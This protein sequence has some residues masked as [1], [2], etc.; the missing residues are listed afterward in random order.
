MMFAASIKRGTAKIE[1]LFTPCIIRRANNP[2]GKSAIPP[3]TISTTTDVSPIANATG[4][5]IA[6]RRIK[7]TMK[8]RRIDM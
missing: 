8:I 2:N 3:V 7:R 5:P 6:R 4:K 1:K